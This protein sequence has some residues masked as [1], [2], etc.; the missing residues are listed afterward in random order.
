MRTEVNLTIGLLLVI[1]GAVLMILQAFGVGNDDFHL[2]WLGA[3]VAVV[4]I[5]I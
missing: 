2:G 4:G 1:A 5:K 3:A